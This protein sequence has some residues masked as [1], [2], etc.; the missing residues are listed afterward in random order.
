LH[1]APIPA[2]PLTSSWNSGGTDATGSTRKPSAMN[3]ASWAAA[4]PGAASLVDSIVQ[5]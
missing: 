2:E 3:A 4:I 5:I 1:K